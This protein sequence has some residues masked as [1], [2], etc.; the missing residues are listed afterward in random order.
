MAYGYPYVQ[1]PVPGYFNT[2]Y[3]PQMQQ[4]QPVGQMQQTVPVI[5]QV[6]D[7]L[8]AQ[9]AQFPMDGTP[10]Y[11]AN[12]NAQEI[13]TKQLNM[14]NGSVI[15]RRYRRIEDAKLE[16]PAYVTREEMNAKLN[17]LYQMLGAATA[18]DNGGD[19]K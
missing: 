19:A 13:Y 1:P 9:N 8:T 12:A 3:M 10:A 6:P 4:A 7:E 16:E 17:E 5:T 15:F 14:S 18:P 11:F 2:N